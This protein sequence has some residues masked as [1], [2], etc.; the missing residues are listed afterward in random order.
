MR[1][2]SFGNEVTKKSLR[3]L[4]SDLGDNI[5]LVFDLIHADNKSH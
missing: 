2:K 5:K 1:T 3:K 4:K